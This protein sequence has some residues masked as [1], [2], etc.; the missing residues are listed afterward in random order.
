LY[1][2]PRRFRTII[3]LTTSSA[4]RILATKSCSPLSLHRTRRCI[5][6]TSPRI[7][8]VI[9][10]RKSIPSSSPL[11]PRLSLARERGAKQLLNLSISQSLDPGHTFCTD[12][13]TMRLP[14]SPQGRNSG[15]SFQTVALI[16]GICLIGSVSASL[17]DRLPE[18]RECVQVSFSLFV[19]WKN[20]GR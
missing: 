4:L 5:N 15:F 9:A 8:T 3:I 18:F 10:A 7:P 13:A 17:G 1:I 12:T 6:S 20:G 11:E 2:H 19:E 16:I 14:P